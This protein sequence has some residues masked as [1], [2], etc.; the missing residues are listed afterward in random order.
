[1]DKYLDEKFLLVRDRLNK[2][3]ISDFLTFDQ[4]SK[5]KNQMG[6]YFVYEDDVI[7]YIGKTNKFNIRFGVDLKHETT[8]T[9]V[10]KLI[11]SGRFQD[12][13]E[14]IDF[15]KNICKVRIVLADSNTEAEAIEAMAIWLLNPVFNKS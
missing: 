6:V 11:K 8:H 1:M 2:V 5:L 12:R 9:L 13:F 7:L 3:L 15:L 14:V 10:A 4:V